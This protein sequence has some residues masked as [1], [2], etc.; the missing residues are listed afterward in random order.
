MVLSSQ[1]LPSAIVVD[2]DEDIAKIFNEFIRLLN[3]EV[4]SF[5]D[6]FNAFTHFKTDPN[7]F[8]LIIS[9]MTMPGMNGIEL[10]RKIREL[11]KSVEIIVITAFDIKDILKRYDTTSLKINHIFQKPVEL[12][13]LK[14]T[15]YKIVKPNTL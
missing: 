9:D 2:D 12:S 5:T 6:P 15:I 8:S 3:V 11:N 14:E 4:I 7:K 1:P 10:A 13:I